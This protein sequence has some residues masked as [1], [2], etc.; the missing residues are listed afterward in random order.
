MKTYK[1]LK[2]GYVAITSVLVLV[3]IIVGIAVASSLNSVSEGQ[4]A[5]NDRLSLQALNNL[6]SCAD[7]VLLRLNE[8]GALP[9]SVTVDT[10]TCTVTLES[11]S[12]SDYTFRVAYTS[13]NFTKTLRI[14][15][16]RS[17]RVYITKWSEI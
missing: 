2:S 13:N 16:T 3:F 1:H 8:D 6:E 14:I 4:I 11:Q 10:Y 7:D 17:D 12:G 5:L 15:A 9:S